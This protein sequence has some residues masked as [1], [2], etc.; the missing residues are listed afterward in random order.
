MSVLKVSLL[1]LGGGA[2]LF[3]LALAY[4]IFPRARDVSDYAVVQPFLH[5]PLPTTRPI[6][7]FRC[8]KGNYVAREHVLLEYDRYAGDKVYALP[9]GTSL[10][11][12]HFTRHTNPVTG[13]T[14][15]IGLGNLT[16]PSGQAVPFEYQWGRVE[17]ANFTP[18]RAQLPTE[19]AIWQVAH[20]AAYKDEMRYP[21]P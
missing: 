16:L 7:L 6:N 8:E 12:T 3:G 15:L 2:V 13:Y 14:H 11:F 19:A 9:V 1:V 21:T 5:R 10:T 18:D 4:V 17:E 20:P